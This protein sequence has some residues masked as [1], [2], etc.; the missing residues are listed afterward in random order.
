MSSLPDGTASGLQT[1]TLTAGVLPPEIDFDRDRDASPTRLNRAMAWLY[2][3]LIVAQS[4]AKTYEGAVEEV[5]ALGITRMDEVL[6]PN[7][8]LAIE[9]AQQLVAIR[10]QWQDDTIVLANHYTR[11]ESDGLFAAKG[12]GH[13]IGNIAGLADALAA[14]AADL[15]TKA[16]KSGAALT[17]NPTAPTQQPGNNST[18]IANTA[19]VTK[20]IAD[21][22]AGA[23]GGDDD[24][25]GT[26]A[27]ALGGKAP[28]ASPQFTSDIRISG[29]IRI[30]DLPAASAV[31]DCAQQN[32]FFAQIA[33]AVSLT[34]QNVPAGVFEWELEMLCVSGS[35]SYP[36]SWK[37]NKGLMP[38]FGAGKTFLIVGRTVD[39]GVTHRVGFSEYTG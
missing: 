18:R 11:A 35:V 22:I 16:P 38:S 25:A 3:Q 32:E 5:R 4:I 14:L 28:K 7:L 20:A 37:W 29:R 19:F 26:M 6:T 23:L 12:H 17:D 36:A 8:Q 2:G 10:D 39:G 33:G 13:A 34:M 1:G 21:L 31:L 15:A 9:I 30:P 27:A 24:F